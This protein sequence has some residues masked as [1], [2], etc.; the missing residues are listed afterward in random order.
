MTISAAKKRAKS[1]EKELGGARIKETRRKI[2]PSCRGRGEGF[3]E[4]GMGEIG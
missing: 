2:E 3:I 4:V 1:K